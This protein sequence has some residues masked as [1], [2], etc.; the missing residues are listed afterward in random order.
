MDVASP[1]RAGTAVQ[2]QGR[3]RSAARFEWD[4]MATTFFEVIGDRPDCPRGH[5]SPM[6]QGEGAR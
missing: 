3:H 2:P 5:Q 6:A 1:L 4:R